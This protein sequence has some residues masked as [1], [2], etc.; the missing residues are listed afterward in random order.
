[1]QFL[2]VGGHIHAEEP[3]AVTT[4]RDLPVDLAEGGLIVGTR[5]SGPQCGVL[6]PKASPGNSGPLGIQCRLRGSNE[7]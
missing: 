7:E 2:P 3:S 4:C 6:L 1:M 5:Q